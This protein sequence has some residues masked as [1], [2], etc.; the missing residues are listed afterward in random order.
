MTDPH[1]LIEVERN[2][3]L[4]EGTPLD[5]LDGQTIVQG[6]WAAYALVAVQG[7]EALTASKPRRVGRWGL[8]SA[9]SSPFG[10]AD[11]P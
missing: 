2:G 8:G 3:G 4:E 6:P 7:A 1:C 11:G 9:T 10:V 5:R